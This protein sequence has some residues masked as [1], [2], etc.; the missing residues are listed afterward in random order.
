[1]VVK[2]FGEIKRSQIQFPVDPLLWFVVVSMTKKVYSLVPATLLL[3]G[4]VSIG[5]AI[6]SHLEVLESLWN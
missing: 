2:V 5:E 3:N 1:M 6:P 4:E